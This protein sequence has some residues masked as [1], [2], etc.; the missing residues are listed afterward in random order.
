[1]LPPFAA[2]RRSAAARSCLRGLL[3]LLLF[4]PRGARA[5]NDDGVLIGV[6]A[7]Q[8]A[9]AVTATIE[10]G[11]ATFYNPAGLARGRANAIDA[12]ANAYGLRIYS[13]DGLLRG[14]DGESRD[15]KVV[16]WL[17]APSLVSY[18]RAFGQVALAFGLFIPAANDLSVLAD[19]RT[20]AGTFWMASVDDR[21]TKYYAGFGLGLPLGSGLRLGFSLLGTYESSAVRIVIA[22]GGPDARTLSL[23]SRSDVRAYGLNARF[24]VQWQHGRWACGLTLVAPDLVAIRAIREASA[25][26]LPADV[27]MRGITFVPAERTRRNVGGALGGAPSLRAGAAYLFGATS[28][29][30]DATLNAPLRSTRLQ[31]ERKVSFNLRLGVSED[32][33]TAWSLGAGLFSD[34]NP[35]V[36]AGTD[37]YGGTAGVQYRRTY[38][39]SDGSELGFATGLS[40]RYAFG[41]GTSFSLSLPSIAPGSEPLIAIGSGSQRT[42]ELSATLGTSITF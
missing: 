6:D 36:E 16:D 28:V 27:G 3:V 9:G 18:V 19:L 21:E 11:A 31:E 38:A 10:G 13:I 42:H 30:V 8:S 34:L 23:F 25:A 33:S 39:L 29:A 40:A 26:T 35:F 1:M 41:R 4:A 37:F 24:G 2:H 5:E 20:N 15:S 17:I 32:V 7:A 22:G 12:S 14:P